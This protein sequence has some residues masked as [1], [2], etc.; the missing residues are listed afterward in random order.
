MHYY[1]RNLGDYAKKAGRLSML[2]HGAYT[3]LLDACYDRERF[4]TESEAFEWTW[5]STPEEE[6]AVRFVLSRFFE[7]QEDGTYVQSRVKEELEMF[8]I[9]GIQNRLIAI[10]RES[11]KQKKEELAK[12]CDQL[13]DEIK[14]APLSKT[15]GAWTS[16]IDA[17]IKEHETPPNQEPITN[18]QEPITN[19]PKSPKGTSGKNP[20]DD[21]PN[22]KKPAIEIKTFIEQCKANDEKVL[23]P[24][25]PIFKYA[26][27]AGIPDDFL[28]LAWREFRDRMISENRRQKDWRMTFRKYIRGNYL[29][30]WWVNSDGVYE[31]TTTGKQAENSQRSKAV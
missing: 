31:L 16:V 23:P 21:K 29:K 14:H 26:T 5:A 19:T 8:K 4:P 13:R 17:L 3:L 25:D 28:T 22:R 9:S 20:S 7:L 30:L 1:T 10:S 15:H 2:Q 24:G 18:N 27:G 11:K 12:A 6:Q